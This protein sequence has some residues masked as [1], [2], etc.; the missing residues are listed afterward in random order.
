MESF[1]VDDGV[2]EKDDNLFS[3]RLVRSQIQG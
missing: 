3:L 2:L 1:L